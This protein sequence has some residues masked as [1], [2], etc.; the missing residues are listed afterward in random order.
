[1]EIEA[2]VPHSRQ[3]EGNPPIVNVFG[4]RYL[5]VQDDDPIEVELDYK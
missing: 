4:G 2:L 5:H 3:N 1:M